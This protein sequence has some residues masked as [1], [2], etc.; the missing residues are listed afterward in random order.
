MARGEQLVVVLN[1]HHFDA[2]ELNVQLSEWLGLRHVRSGPGTARPNM[3]AHKRGICPLP[4]NSRLAQCEP[5]LDAL[6]HESQLGRESS[7]ARFVIAAT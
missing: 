5:S 7:F 3:T 2:Q 4:C 1:I 6:D